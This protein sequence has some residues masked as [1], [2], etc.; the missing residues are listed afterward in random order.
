MNKKWDSPATLKAAGMGPT[1]SLSDGQ[2]FQV[3]CVQWLTEMYR[4]LRP[5]GV[6]KLFGGCR[7]FHRL[8]MAM[9]HVGF[10]HMTM[11]AWTTG[12]GMPKGLN[13]PSAIGK[14]YDKN[15]I[16]AGELAAYLGALPAAPAGLS[17]EQVDLLTPDEWESLKEDLGLDGR[18]DEYVGRA[19]KPTSEDA[20]KWAGWGTG[21][22]PAWE[23][24]VVAYKPLR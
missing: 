16:T 17:P 20:K 7:M 11:E 1:K 10:V 18:F 23:P 3:W 22:K 4:T 9:E 6:V 2:K 14:M 5:G 13:I 12:E 21:L 15:Q 8:A 19:I 24:I